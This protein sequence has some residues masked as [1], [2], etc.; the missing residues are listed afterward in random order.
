MATE[1]LPGSNTV[2]VSMDRLVPFEDN[3]RK[4]TDSSHIDTL[5][6]DI[7]ENGLLHPITVRPNA[8]DNLEVVAGWRRVLAHKL[9]GRDTVLANVIEADDEHAFGISLAEN[10][11][12]HPLKNVDKCLAIRRCYDECKGNMREAVAKTRLAPSTI[13]KYVEI[14]NLPPEIIARLDSE[15][16]DRLTLKEAH[17]MAKPQNVAPELPEDAATLASAIAGEEAGGAEGLEGDEERPAK[18]RRQTTS[19]KKEPWIYDADKNPLPIPEALY[20]AV[21]QMVL[22]HSA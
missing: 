19:V 11:H 7:A 6:A 21:Y 17:A 9:L 16:D 20:G 12:R 4:D 22:N 10:M 1:A 18:R 5:A 2:L 13:R 8:D 3:V 15:G 14:S